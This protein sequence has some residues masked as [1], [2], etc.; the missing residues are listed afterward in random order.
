[1]PALGSL[2][3]MKEGYLFTT[4]F[5]TWAFCML[6]DRKFL[7][8]AAIFVGAAFCSLIGLMH[9]AVVSLDYNK[10]GTIEKGIPASA[11]G[12]ANLDEK[13]G[14]P[15]WKFIVGYL[16]MAASCGL[17]FGLQKANLI[18]PP[19]EEET[20]VDTEGPAKAAAVALKE[21]EENEA[22]AAEAAPV[23]EKAASPTEEEKAA[24]LDI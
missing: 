2:G 3:F 8:A 11:S 19:I 4:V 22:A 14:L 17:L 10:W 16:L 23:E 1:M 9:S 12:V 24:S 5:W 7:Q 13:D 21:S 18:D 15:G 20:E 6:T